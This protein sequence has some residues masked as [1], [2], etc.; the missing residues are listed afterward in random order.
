[1]YS[2]HQLLD[3]RP[4][5]WHIEQS[6]IKRKKKQTVAQMWGIG[7]TVKVLQAGRQLVELGNSSAASADV[8][9]EHNAFTAAYH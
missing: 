7:K 8:V 6:S 9:Q 3:S 5:V 2:K 1:M 4:E